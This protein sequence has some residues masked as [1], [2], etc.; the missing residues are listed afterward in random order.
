MVTAVHNL[1]TGT[2]G[3]DFSQFQAGAQHYFTNSPGRQSYW[4]KK[5]ADDKV[6]E[7]Y[8]K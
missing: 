7:E 3:A 1:F 2:T 6:V 5:P 8:M 4:I